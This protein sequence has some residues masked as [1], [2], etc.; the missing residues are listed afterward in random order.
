M[1]LSEYL[2]DLFCSLGLTMLFW[3]DDDFA[4]APSCMTYM[5]IELTRYC[6]LTP[7]LTLVRD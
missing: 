3:G 5:F 4:A 6:Y 2:N 1:T 7:R